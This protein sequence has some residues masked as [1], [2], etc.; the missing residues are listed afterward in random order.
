MVKGNINS[1]SNLWA[2]IMENGILP[3]NKDTLSKRIEKHPNVKSASQD[4]LLNGPLQNIHPF[5]FQSINK[6]RKASIRTRGGSGPSGMHA[7]CWRRILAFN[8]FGTSS[9][10]LC[11]TFANVNQ[12][13]CTELAETHTIEAF[14]SCH[15][16]ALDKIED[17]DPLGLVKFYI[18]LPVKSLIQF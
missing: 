13:L 1:A 11:K 5:K 12:K 9:S 15:L 17:F 14:L 7:N 4:T 10:D 8:N 3:L 18:K 6:E 16:V 2:N